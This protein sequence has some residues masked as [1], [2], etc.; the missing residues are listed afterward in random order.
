MYTVNYCSEIIDKKEIYKFKGMKDHGRSDNCGQSRTWITQ[1]SGDM[2]HCEE[3]IEE[4]FSSFGKKASDTTGKSIIAQEHKW[5]SLKL[6][7]PVSKNDI[8]ESE[9]L[10]VVSQLKVYI[11][12]SNRSKSPTHL[13]YLKSV[14]ERKR[15]RWGTIRHGFEKIC[16]FM[17]G[18]MEIQGV[19]FLFYQ[20]FLVLFGFRVD[21]ELNSF[22][23]DSHFICHTSGRMPSSVFEFFSGQVKYWPLGFSSPL[24]LASVWVGGSVLWYSL[25][26]FVSSDIL[27]RK[28]FLHFSVGSWIWKC[29][30]GLSL[31]NSVGE[32]G[33]WLRL[34][35]WRFLFQ[36]YSLL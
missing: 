22:L 25:E 23:E 10:S 4:S 33:I 32:D 31:K 2:E 17:V 5:L 19:F 24:G 8:P 35:H 12:D 1:S 9:I 26:L 20:F 21:Q 27:L 15:F 30:L 16:N 34:A 29:F 18:R 36:R 3:M 7:G 14:I 6:K 11:T 13:L 28:A